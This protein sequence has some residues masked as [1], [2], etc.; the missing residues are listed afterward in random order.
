M[1]AL[2][3]THIELLRI[4][5]SSGVPPITPIVRELPSKPSFD[6]ALHRLLLAW[7]DNGKFSAD[8][9]VLLRQAVRWAPHSTLFIGPLHESVQHWLPEVS[10]AKLAGGELVARPYAPQWLEEATPCDL[11]P[12]ERTLDERFAAEPFLASLHYDRWLSAAQKE[13]AWGVMN[14][15]PGE[16]LIVVL[17]TGS[18]KSLC[19]QLLPRFDQGLTVVV[20]PT[21]ALAIDQ[22][23]KAQRLLRDLPQVNPI[24]FSSDEDP[25]LIVQQI[26]NRA[27]RL[28]FTSPESCVSGRLRPVLDELARAGWFNN[29]VID[30]GHLI[31]TWGAQFRVEFQILAPRR[32]RWLELSGDKLRTLIFSATMTQQCRELLADMFSESGRGE[33]FVCQR[34]RPELNYFHHRFKEPIERDARLFE[35]L[36]HLPRPGIL[37]VTEVKEA[38]EYERRLREEQ[39]FGRVRSFHGETRRGER[40]ELLRA[41][42]ANEIDLMVAT[43]AFGVGVDKSDVRT[44]IHA[45]YPENLDRYYQEVGRGGRDGWSSV[46][47][48]LP[49]EKDRRVARNLS[50]TLMTSEMLQQRW[51]AMFQHHRHV[52]NY[53]YRLPVNARR[54]GLVGTFT[55]AENVRWNKRLLVQLHRAKLIELLDVTREQSESSDE[56]PEEWAEVRVAFPPDARNLGERASAMRA[57]EIANFTRGFDQLDELLDGTKCVGRII[58]KLYGMESDQRVC[59]GC[60]NCRVRDFSPGTCPPLRFP[61]THSN[62]TAH[63]CISVSNWP[64]PFQPALRGDFFAF[65]NLLLTRKQLRR[66]FVPERRFDELLTL[67]RSELPSNSLDLYRVDFLRDDVTRNTTAG[68]PSERFVFL[69]I[70]MISQSAIVFARGRSAVH[71]R[72]GFSD[73]LDADGRDVFVREVA[74]TYHSPEAWLSASSQ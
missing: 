73:A 56:D 15:A 2:P 4:C 39:H 38:R 43:S 30:E 26:K 50:V 46:C 61:E 35:A 57:L 72:C 20:V 5:L 69:H 41:W 3:M 31:E 49:T 67:F 68:E 27:T 54:T 62:A 60:P 52:E 19:F 48:F 17:P 11:L 10:L 13:A 14:T 29:L 16:T 45:C 36:R 58:Q 64:D 71:L 9:A 65:F 40:R 37:Y 66:F 53:R 42:Q 34:T 25:N 32:R 33:E 24:Y 47:L 23:N 22:K 59:G 51:D 70:G 55:Y 74:H 63:P 44:V 21:V 1:L 8:E 28:L 7:S 18:G 6:Y 12:I